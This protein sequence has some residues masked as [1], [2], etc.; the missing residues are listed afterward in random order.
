M[1]MRPF[2]EAM[3]VSCVVP[4]QSPSDDERMVFDNLSFGMERGDIIDLVGPS[5]S[6]KSSLLTACARLNPHAHG[7]FVL[8]GVG[9]DEFSAQQWR[10]D[11]SYLPQKPILTGKDVAEAIRLPWTLAIR[12]KGGK[13]ARLL[14]DERIRTT[15]DAMG[16]EDID[17]TRAPHDLSGGQAARVALAR[18]LLT[19][20]K[21][22]LADEVDA[23]LDDDNASKVAAIMADAAAHGMAIIR[24][25]HRP[26][27]GRATRTLML[28]AER[29]TDL[30]RDKEVRP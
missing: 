22:L 12:G 28:D 11:V 6:G 19:D 15:L 29:L 4:A 2:F 26:P 21:V 10:R 16:C 18:T 25:R 13:A 9:S 8:D 14:P 24:I 1:N 5:G 20:P 3:S 17:L 7:M 23:G 27:D 30:T